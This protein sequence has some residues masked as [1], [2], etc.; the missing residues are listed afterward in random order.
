MI[1]SKKLVVAGF[2]K[3]FTGE[4]AK[5]FEVNA[6]ANDKITFAYVVDEAVWKEYDAKESRNKVLFFEYFN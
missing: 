4:K 3:D 6:L 5:I 1:S 2:F